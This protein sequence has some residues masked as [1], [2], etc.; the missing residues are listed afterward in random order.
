MLK[1]FLAA[2]ATL[3]LLAGVAM[4]ETVTTTTTE[5][6]APVMVPVPV[7]P[8]PATVTESTTQRTVGRDGLVTDQ[9]KTTTT[10]T[11]MSPFGDTTTTHRTTES[12]T[13]R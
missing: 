11:S 2:T 8:A 4:A 13:V 10:G 6:A 12:T 7:V 9:S 3:T 1:T 5:T